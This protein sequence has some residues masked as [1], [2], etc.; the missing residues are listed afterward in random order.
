VRE[1]VRDQ[2]HQRAIAGENG[3]RREGEPRVLHAAVREAR[4]QD[5]QV[6]TTPAVGP[7]EPLGRLDHLL[8][9]GELPR[10]AVDDR[11]LGV[12]AGAL[13][14]RQELDV[15]DRERDEVRRHRR[16]H[17]EPVDA[18][19]GAGDR[20]LRAHQRQQ[21]GRDPHHGVVRR[22]HARAVL[23]GDPGASE[24]RLVLG[25][26]EL[27]PRGG[28]LRL[29]PL[30]RPRVV[31]RR[32]VDDDLVG[33]PHIDGQRLPE[34]RIVLPELP[35]QVRARG[36][37]H[38]GDR[39]PPRVED[40][41]VRVRGPV[42]E[43]ERGRPRQPPGVEVDGEVECEVADRD[44]VGSGVGV[45]ISDKGPRHGPTVV[46]RAGRLF[47]YAPPPGNGQESQQPHRFACFASENTPEFLVSAPRDV[48]LGRLEG[49]ARWPENRRRS[50]R[51]G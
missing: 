38:R 48:G 26:E 41:G 11:G 12:D 17:R 20:V 46:G 6:V 18:V 22:P 28:L 32:V 27:L 34:R 42:L 2:R 33:E 4:R 23:A 8:G 50:R 39:Q 13:A 36:V 44:L 47:S 31:G 19:L 10:G 45:R 3:R 9:V 14:E 7:V 1:L 30:Q 15:T 29:E 40:E 21:V 24:D 5:Q 16:R 51:A 35:R 43:V 25:E 37:R 49:T